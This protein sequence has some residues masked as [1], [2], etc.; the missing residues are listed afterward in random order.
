M[1][2]LE[3]I[4]QRVERLA[5]EKADDIALILPKRSG[6]D[7]QLTWRELNGKSNHRARQIAECGV[8]ES[9]VVAVAL[10]GELDHVITTLAAWKI[11]A[12]VVPVDPHLSDA[13]VD[14]IVSVISPGLY[15][16]RSACSPDCPK[17]DPEVWADGWSEENPPPPSGEPRSAST[18][19]GTQGRPRVIHRKR[20]WMFDPDGIPTPHERRMG[21]TSYQTHLVA[22]P[23]FHSGFGALFGPLGLGH[24]VVLLP[25][26]HPSFVLDCVERY[27]VN[28]MRLVPTMMKLLLLPGARIADRDLSSIEVIHHGTASCPPNV[29][30]A[31][32]DLVGPER[33]YEG[34]SSQEQFAYIYIRGDEWLARPGSVGRPDPGAVA[35]VDEAGDQVPAG[36]TGRIFLRSNDGSGPDYLGAG[37]QL[38]SWQGKY[39]TVGD[40]GHLDDAGYLYVQGRANDLINVGGISVYPAEV[41]A[42][43]LASDQ[44]VDACVVPASHP[45]LGQVPHALVVPA[46]GTELSWPELEAYCRARLSAHKVPQSFTAVDVLPRT[47]AG[48][49]RRSA[50][51]VE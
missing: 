28:F 26:F 12:T 10:P 3:S 1:S 7:R 46:Q 45:V 34:Y 18:T 42:V 17:I 9:T 48:K 29:K 27:S 6:E 25:R 16:T 44:I 15:V 2:Q 30:I 32:F 19:G 31:W 38:P 49:L 8:G 39:F 5:Q 14:H 11:G 33:V 37:E 41:E 22:A 20:G 24:R 4:T 21:F 13:E 43:L 51:T 23:L 50:L 47:G 35:I 36:T 40:L